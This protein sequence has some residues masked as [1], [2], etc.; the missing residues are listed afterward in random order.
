MRTENQISG[1]ARSFIEEARRR[2][3]VAAAVE[4][5][6]DVGY[7]KASLARIARQAGIS[8]GVISYH[9]DGKDEL[10]REVVIQLF[11]SGAEYMGPQ[12][13]A[14]T[15]PADQLTAYLRS[16]LDFLDTNRRFIAAMT[17]VV[18]N[19]RDADGN[20]TF[21]PGVGE[22]QIVGPL[23]DILQRGQK[24]GEFGDFD[25]H[26]MALQIRDAIDGAAGRVSRGIGFDGA[27][28]AA[29]LIST[30]EKAT[31]SQ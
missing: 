9:F 6:A 7:G 18:L 20:L 22:E 23:V 2:Q 19:L 28:Y 30:F 31:R 15:T 26:T 12:I 3:I 29:Q 5:I 4:V 16:N 13:A 27:T 17:D 10:M 24:S 21:Q 11:V 14:A 8:K 25:A 1:Q